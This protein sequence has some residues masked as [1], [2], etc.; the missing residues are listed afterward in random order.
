MAKDT[1]NAEA[2]AN[3]RS[4]IEARQYVLD[5]ECDEAQ[6]TAADEKAF[7]D[8]HPWDEY[9]AWHL[10]QTVVGATGRP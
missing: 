5:G 4:L 6:P 8:R 2:V 10:V 7:L 1:L 3:A 9:A